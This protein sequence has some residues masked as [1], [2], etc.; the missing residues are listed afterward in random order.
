MLFMIKDLTIHSSHSALLDLA[1][2]VLGQLL[3]YLALYTFVQKFVSSIARG[4]HCWVISGRGFAQGLSGLFEP[5]FRI[6]REFVQCLPV[7]WI[8]EI[9]SHQRPIPERLALC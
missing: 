7:L 4:G 3:D 2:A 8:E 6:V 5:P 9:P 1:V